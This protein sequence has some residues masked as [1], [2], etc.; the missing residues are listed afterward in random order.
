MYI[1]YGKGVCSGIAFGKLF[2]IRKKEKTVKKYHVNDTEKEIKRLDDAFKKA[3]EQLT[4][5]YK[6]A[7]S[8]VGEDNASIFEIH[9]MMLKD[10]DFLNSIYSCVK[11]QRL[12]AEA[13]VAIAEDNFSQI[14][15][16]MDDSYMKDRASDVHDISGRL[17][18]ILTNGGTSANANAL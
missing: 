12:N 14:F 8:E 5:L 9:R 15:S 11:D 7:L 2:Q 18:K 6:K 4:M 16:S 10:D 1:I 3:D 13:A 17:I